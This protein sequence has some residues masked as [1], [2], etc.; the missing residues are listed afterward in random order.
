MVSDDGLAGRQVC[1]MWFNMMLKDDFKEKTQNVKPRTSLYKGV[2]ESKV[3][4]QR[5]SDQRRK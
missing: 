4:C 5:I 3:E 1:C 2:K